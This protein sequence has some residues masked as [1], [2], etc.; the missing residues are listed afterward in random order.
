M[1]SEPKQTLDERSK[2][3][4]LRL[5]RT[6]RPSSPARQTASR[7]PTPA[8]LRAPAQARRELH[9]PQHRRRERKKRAARAALAGLCTPAERRRLPKAQ[10]GPNRL[11]F[12]LGVPKTPDPRGADADV[13]DVSTPGREAHSSRR[14][15][16]LG[17]LRRRARALRW[18]DLES[19]AESGVP[20]DPSAEWPP[21]PPPEAELSAPEARRRPRRLDVWGAAVQCAF[22]V[23]F[24][25]CP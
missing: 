10:Q 1:V 18:R 3:R 24:S 21:P 5:G 7:K 19:W 23:A 4:A 16:A 25:P 12:A 14:A 20:R 8:G 13:R 9:S 15:R 22:P 11:P 17:S 6:P 2:R